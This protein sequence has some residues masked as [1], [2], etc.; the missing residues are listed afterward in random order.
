MN[1]IKIKTD[2]SAVTDI[3]VEIG[4]QELKNSIL[5]NLTSRD[6]FAKD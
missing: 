5:E 4:S 1:D 3:S 6:I 2:T